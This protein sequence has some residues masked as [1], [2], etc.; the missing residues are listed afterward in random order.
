MLP[1][2][3]KNQNSSPSKKNVEEETDQSNEI[4][5]YKQRKMNCSHACTNPGH[6]HYFSFNLYP[7]RESRSLLSGS[8]TCLVK[9]QPG[10][11]PSPPLVF[12]AAYPNHL[13]HY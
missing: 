12:S 5:V 1:P 3:F 13:F 2:N 7:P 11:P 8:T 4:D 10:N 6:D 9:G